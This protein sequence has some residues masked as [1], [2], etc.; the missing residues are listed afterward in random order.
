MD[1]RRLAIIGLTAA[2]IGSLMPSSAAGGTSARRGLGKK[3]FVVVAVV[4]SG[5]NPYHSDFRRNDLTAHPS[6]YIEGFP[7]DTKAL[8]LSFG[9]R[10]YHSA[11]LRD[12]ERWKKVK[13]GKLVWIPGTNIIGAIDVGGSSSSFLDK[14]GHG[15]GVA[16]VAA[17]KTHGPRDPD[18]LL[19]VVTGFTA[20]L[21]WAARQ[22]WID[23][24]TNSWSTYDTEPVTQGSAQASRRAVADGKVVCFASANLS[25]PHW[26]TGEQGPSWNLNV[27]AA[28]SKNR[29]EHYYT[30]WPN[31]VLGIAN[32]KAA[33]HTSLTG[34]RDFN[35]TSAAAP[36][37]CGLIAKVLADVRGRLGDGRQGPHKAALA[38]GPKLKGSMRDG[39][40]TNDELLDAI[41]S[42]AVPALP[43]PPDP[44][45]DASIPAL[46]VAPWLRGGYGIV[47]KTSIKQALEVIYGS[48]AR[49]MRT[50]E[51][52]WVG[53]TD[54]IRNAL[55]GDPP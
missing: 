30:G 18:V 9:E 42:T 23:V 34:E 27:G 22:P 6:T 3:P 47:D 39:A 10:D 43:N 29:G 44:D 17:G 13:T 12:G 8:K 19:V 33:E 37:V 31:D 25:T 5:I 1:L 35:G 53:L 36:H 55:W 41:Q 24:I 50:N 49:P 11:I 15:T 40:L 28:S 4:D 20:G 32:V 21:Q 54:T 7:N 26:F 2:A 14:V 48:K 16:S 45:D 51:D 38:T 46:P 52:T